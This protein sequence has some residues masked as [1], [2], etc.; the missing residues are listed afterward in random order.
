MER[1]KFGIVID[2]C[3]A[4]I[5][6]VLSNDLT[7]F[8]IT[9]ELTQCI[10]ENN[11]SQMEVIDSNMMTNTSDL[12][13]SKAYILIEVTEYGNAINLSAIQPL[14]TQ[15]QIEQLNLKWRGFLS[16]AALERIETNACDE[17]AL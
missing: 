16:N 4:L 12:Q 10:F 9:T 13:F 2:Q 15:L 8:S 6:W 5:K 7:E 17:S 14:N 3:S 1:T 11:P